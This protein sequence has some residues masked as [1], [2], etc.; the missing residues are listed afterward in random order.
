MSTFLAHSKLSVG[1][2][3]GCSRR[4]FTRGSSPSRCKGIHGRVGQKCHG[5]RSGV[6]ISH[7][8]HFCTSMRCG[9]HPILS[10]VAISSH[11]CFSSSGGGSKFKETRCCC[12]NSSKTKARVASFAKCG[13][14]GG[15]DASSDVHGSR[16]MCHPCVRVHCTRVL[17]GCVRTVGRCGPRSP[18][19]VACFGRVHRHTNV[20][21]VAIACPRSL[22][23]G[24]GVHR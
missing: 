9:K 12:S 22:N 4:K 1:S 20:P 11:G 23:S 5:K 19:V 18:G 21:G 24:R 16:T 10:T 17:L 7:R 15:M 13:M 3:R 2:S 6:C 8:P 14:T